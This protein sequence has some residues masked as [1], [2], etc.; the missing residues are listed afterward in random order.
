M[1]R[2]T[3]P[4]ERDVRAKRAVFRREIG[5]GE[6]RAELRMQG[7]EAIDVAAETNP[8]DARAA[9]WAERAGVIERQAPR[10]R[11][12]GRACADRAQRLQTLG[13]LLAEEGERD[14]HARRVHP[15]IVAVRLRGDQPSEVGA[16][17]VG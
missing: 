14:V 3:T 17:L 5:P 10:A 16:D 15:A 7:A 8:Q 6:R 11:A 9:P 12:R 2:L 4:G 13:G 1:G